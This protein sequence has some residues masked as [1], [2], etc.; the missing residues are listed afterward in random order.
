MCC[1]RSFVSFVIFTKYVFK[2]NNV[3]VNL[4]GG[5]LERTLVFLQELDEHHKQFE[6]F[7]ALIEGVI[8]W[9]NDV[10]FL[11]YSV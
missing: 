7:A 11:M 2:S 10:V 9:L 4:G 3:H 5:E 6:T 1:S 8:P